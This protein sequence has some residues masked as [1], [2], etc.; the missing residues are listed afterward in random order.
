M[1]EDLYVA[2]GLY[3]TVFLLIYSSHVQQQSANN[4]VQEALPYDTMASTKLQAGWKP[5]ECSL[6]T[7]CEILLNGLFSSDSFHHQILLMIMDSVPPIPFLLPTT[8]EYWQSCQYG[9]LTH[10]QMALVTYTNFSLLLLYSKG[11]IIG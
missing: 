10:T 8:M 1:P 9:I 4:K 7:I 5:K 11:K 6:K 2:W 3:Q